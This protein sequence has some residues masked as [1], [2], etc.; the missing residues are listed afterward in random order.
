MS[1]IFHG[2]YSGTLQ[3]LHYASMQS[4]TSFG[5]QYKFWT[6]DNVAVPAGVERCDASDII[7]RSLYDLWLSL[8]HKRKLQNF[9]NYFRY[10][11]IL[12]HGGW[13][14]DMDFICVKKHDFTQPYVFCTTA[15]PVWPEVQSIVGP[16]GNI[17]NGLFKAPANSPFL[18]ELIKS[19]DSDFYTGNS[20][21]FGNWGAIAFTKAV[22]KHHLEKYQFVDHRPICEEFSGVFAP[23]SP[24]YSTRLFESGYDIP[25]DVYSVHFFESFYPEIIAGNKKAD[26]DSIYTRLLRQFG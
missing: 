8:K 12:Q 13:W 23:F 16:H 15:A 1:E 4:Y 24:Y 19:I 11:L 7:P 9:A 17:P 3:P 6:Y 22:Y 25:R 18:A 14:V 5:H 10:L 26:D 21:E 20:P 2:F